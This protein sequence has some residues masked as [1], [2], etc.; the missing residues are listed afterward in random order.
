MVLQLVIQYFKLRARVSLENNELKFKNDLLRKNKFDSAEVRR[1]V[2]PHF[3]HAYKPF[4]L[5]RREIFS[6]VWAIA[7]TAPGPRVDQSTPAQL[8][9]R[10]ISETQPHNIGELIY[11]RK[12]SSSETNSSGSPFRRR[13]DRVSRYLRAGAKR[14]GP[15]ASHNAAR[16]GQIGRQRARGAINSLS[17][18]QIIP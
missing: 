9:P 14:R 17:T 5:L 12:F 6:M 2:K 13:G 11:R 8:P 7:I 18:R 15:G 1:N 3:N 10:A 16:A 4:Q